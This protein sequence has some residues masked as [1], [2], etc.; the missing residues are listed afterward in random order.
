MPRNAI[1]LIKGKINIS[2]TAETSVHDHQANTAEKKECYTQ[3]GGVKSESQEH[4]NNF[5]KGVIK[6]EKSTNTNRRNKEPTLTK[7]E[8]N[9]QNY[10]N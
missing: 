4:R 10:R 5:I 9:Q 6:K 8:I 3:E 2:R 7:P 1:S